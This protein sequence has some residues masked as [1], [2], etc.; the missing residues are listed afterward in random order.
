[1]Y[2]YCISFMYIYNMYVHSTRHD[3]SSTR[4][5]TSSTRHD[6]SSTSS[7][8]HDT[9][10]QRRGNTASTNARPFKP[11]TPAS[12]GE[13][14]E[15][16]EEEEEEEEDDDEEEE[17]CADTLTGHGGQALQTYVAGTPRSKET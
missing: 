5:D 14:D 3:T 8:R 12:L 16:E 13:E 6:T 9:S 17:A 1:M 7:T 11:H 15:E 2:A 4:H 10:S